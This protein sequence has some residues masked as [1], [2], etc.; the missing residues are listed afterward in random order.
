MRT[1]THV[2]TNP[3]FDEFLANVAA[4]DLARAKRWLKLVRKCRD[5]APDITYQTR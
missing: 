5:R 3:F 4:K 1:R 2:S